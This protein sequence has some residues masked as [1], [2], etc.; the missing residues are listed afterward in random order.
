MTPEQIQNALRPYFPTD[1]VEVYPEGDSA[2]VVIVSK[3][4]TCQEKAFREYTIR[5][6]LPLGFEGILSLWTP[7]EVIERFTQEGGPTT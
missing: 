7:A 5:A 1:T 6:V 2:R 3:K 4:F